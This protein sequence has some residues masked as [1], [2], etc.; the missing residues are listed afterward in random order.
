[1]C[2]QAARLTLAFTHAEHDLCDMLRELSGSRAP[3]LHPC[4]VKT[5]HAFSAYLCSF[6]VASLLCRL[7][8]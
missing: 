8:G 2:V 6:G 7:R 4:T 5:L 3:G 1:M